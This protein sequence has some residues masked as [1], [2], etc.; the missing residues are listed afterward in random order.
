MSPLK[1]GTLAKRANVN[2][3]TLRYYEREGLLPEPERSETGYRLYADEDVKRVRFIKRAQELGFSLKEIKELL[4]LKLDASQSASQVKKLAELKIQDIE[5]K[6]QSLR[7]MKSI[8]SELTEACS[9]KGSVDH[10]PI[11]SCLDECIPQKGGETQ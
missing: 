9:G 7:A 4:A 1:S 2:P 10:C 6:I 8:L 11:L 5:A 3:E